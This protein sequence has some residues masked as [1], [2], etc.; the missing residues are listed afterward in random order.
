ML[1]AK[2]EYFRGLA[3][4]GVGTRFGN[5]WTGQEDKDMTG[6]ADPWAQG[7]VEVWSGGQQRVFENTGEASKLKNKKTK[8]QRIRVW[9]SLIWDKVASIVKLI[10]S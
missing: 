7:I 1:F 8:L 9:L 10:T 3:Q 4:A 2:S 6:I 5:F